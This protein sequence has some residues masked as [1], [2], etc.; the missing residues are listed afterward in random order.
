MTMQI[1]AGQF[2]GKTLKKLTLPGLEVCESLYMP[3]QRLCH[4]AHEGAFVCLTVTGG[5][6]ERVGRYRREAGPMH[7]AYHPPGEDH[8]LI[9]GNTEVRCLNAAMDAGLI[10]EATDEYPRL[11]D[12]GDA[13]AAG[14]A[15]RLYFAFRV[16]D[17]CAKLTIESLFF[18]LLAELTHAAPPS[19]KRKVSG[20]LLRVRELLDDG[21]HRH[22]GLREIAGEVGMHPVCLAREFRRQYGCSV[23]EYARYRR[24]FQASRQLLDTDRPLADIALECGFTDQPHFTRRFKAATA[25]T[26]GRI[27]AL[28][29][30]Y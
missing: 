18:E 3:G 25:S 21:F 23:G 28:A 19:H 27:R 8:D 2:H 24:I 7:L 12:P 26:P 6:S 29:R 15:A 17:M 13:H 10:Q 16:P 1:E 11:R 30:S 22:L 4:H 20:K 9:F 14:I 5:Y